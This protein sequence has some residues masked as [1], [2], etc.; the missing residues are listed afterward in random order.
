LLK[1]Y[2]G[3]VI[4]NCGDVGI[5]NHKALNENGNLQPV[6]QKVTLTFKTQRNITQLHIPE[7]DKST[8]TSA[9]LPL[10]K[11]TLQISQK[12]NLETKAPIF[13]RMKK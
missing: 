1:N 4:C 9:I 12:F 3:T 6:N 5:K 7:N 8:T 10:E 2:F 13:M 11:F